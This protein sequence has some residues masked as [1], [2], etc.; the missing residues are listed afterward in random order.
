MFAG[1][2]LKLN[3]DSAIDKPA[4]FFSGHNENGAGSVGEWMRE[5]QTRPSHPAPMTNRICQEK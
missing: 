4:S 1:S 2:T 3:Y 5:S